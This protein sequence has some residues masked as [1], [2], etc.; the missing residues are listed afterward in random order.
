MEVIYNNKKVSNNSFL[1]PYETK[2]K[3]KISFS[4]ENNKLYTLLMYNKT[5]I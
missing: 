5:K 2:I 4:F 1:K 3:P